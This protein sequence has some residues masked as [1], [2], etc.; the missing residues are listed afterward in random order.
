MANSH[1]NLYSYIA[2]F[3]GRWNGSIGKIQRLQTAIVSDVPLDREGILEYLYK[4]YE[5]ISELTWK[6][7]TDINKKIMECEI[8]AEYGDH[9]DVDRDIEKRI[10]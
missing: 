9:I 3:I 1:M 8:P 2:K 6:E 4:D 7:L 5:H 10:L